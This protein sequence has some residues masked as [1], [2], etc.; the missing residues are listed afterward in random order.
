MKLAVMI[1]LVGTLCLIDA[2]PFQYQ[3]VMPSYTPYQMIQNPLV[4]SGRQTTTT[5]NNNNPFGNLFGK[6][7]M[8]QAEKSL[9]ERIMKANT[10]VDALAKQNEKNQK[11]LRGE[12]DT[13]SST[14]TTTG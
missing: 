13:S 14:T 4:L 12:V 9:M 2:A 1:V 7:N 11:R 6:G 3:Y 10:S 8:S 5:T